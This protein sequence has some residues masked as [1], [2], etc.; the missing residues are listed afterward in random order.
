MA[1]A[2]VL[3]EHYSTRAFAIVAPH[4]PDSPDGT[5]Y[6][7]QIVTMPPLSL[8]MS[9]NKREHVTYNWATG[10]L[11]EMAGVPDATPRLNQNLG[12]LDNAALTEQAPSVDHRTDGSAG[13]SRSGGADAKDELHLVAWEALNALAARGLLRIKVMQPPAGPA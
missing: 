7:D 9:P 8:K 11:Q 2:Y 12:A 5:I 1:L 4:D 3:C 10:T 13:E 6:P